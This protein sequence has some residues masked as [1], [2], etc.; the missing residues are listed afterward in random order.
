MINRVG[1]TFVHRMQEETGA[2]APDVVRA[3]LIVREAFG[4][5]DLW[6]A[7]EALDGKVPDRA[8]T[9]III[10][11]GRLIVRGTLWFLRNRSHLA[12]L[13]R[14]IR[15]FQAG[16]ER[17]A[18]AL[19]EIL[20]ASEKAGFAAAAERLQKEGV[21][22]DLARRAAGSDTLFG[23]LDIV[24][25]ASSL[26]R[27]IDAVARAYFAIAGELEFP[28]LRAAIGMLAGDDHWHG[29]AK[30]ALRDDLSSMLR[31]V[32]EDVLRQDVLSAADGGSR[33]LE[34]AQRRALRA[35]PP[36]A[37][38]S[39]QRR[40][41]GP[42]DALGRDARAAQPQPYMIQPKPAH[43]VHAWVPTLPVASQDSHWSH[44]YVMALL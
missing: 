29:L 2:G 12:D 10:D 30:A 33:G 22:A 17:I 28:W 26:K 4:F 39:A 35:L 27:D 41:A 42:R 13:T 19:A 15:H 43:A 3:Y 21:P 8:Q 32:T 23:V 11:G 40:V 36:G 16:A 9:A 31:A 5:V 38:R 34:G 24:E 1:S 6:R 25:V 14:S 18:S 7:V 20:P 37:R 44:R